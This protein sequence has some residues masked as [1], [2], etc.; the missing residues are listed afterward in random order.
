LKREFDLASF[1]ICCL[2]MFVLH[3]ATEASINTF[4]N[5]FTALIMF[6]GMSV[7]SIKSHPGKGEQKYDRRTPDVSQNAARPEAAPSVAN[8]S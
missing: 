1:G 2:L 6:A 4:T 7:A 3:N 8:A 5:F